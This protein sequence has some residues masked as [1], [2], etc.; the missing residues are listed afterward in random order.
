MLLTPLVKKQRTEQGWRYASV[1]EAVR[2]L[3][4]TRWSLSSS[5]E[6]SCSVVSQKDFQVT[7]TFLKTFAM[8]L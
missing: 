7:Q 2:L 6:I 5:R 3:T 1:A 8:F 4:A